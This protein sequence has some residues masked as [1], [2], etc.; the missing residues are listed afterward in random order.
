MVWITSLPELVELLTSDSGGHHRGRIENT[1]RGP[2]GRDQ[3][4]RLSSVN[5]ISAAATVTSGGMKVGVITLTPGVDR[6]IILATAA[7]TMVVRSVQSVF[8]SL[9]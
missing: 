8:P 7:T 9:P 2:V 6:A 3:G 4:F 1:Q 5:S